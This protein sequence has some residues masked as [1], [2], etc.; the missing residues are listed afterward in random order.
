VRAIDVHVVAITLNEHR[1]DA[2]IACA[3]RRR[4]ARW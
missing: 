4:V 1:A 3:T 2:T